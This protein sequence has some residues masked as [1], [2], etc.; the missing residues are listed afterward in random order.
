MDIFNTP[1]CIERLAFETY[2]LDLKKPMEDVGNLKCIAYQSFLNFVHMCLLHKCTHGKEHLCKLFDYVF[3]ELFDHSEINRSFIPPPFEVIRYERCTRPEDN[4]IGIK[5]TIEF[6]S[7][8]I[9]FESQK[10]L[11]EF[12]LALDEDKELA[13]LE[14]QCYQ[15]FDTNSYLNVFENSPL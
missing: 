10:P 14:K 1:M 3:K 12:A 2:Q 9:N 11:F 13:E 15:A 8:F 7:R 6:D 5:V 4:E